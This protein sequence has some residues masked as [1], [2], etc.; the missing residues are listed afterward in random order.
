MFFFVDFWTIIWIF[1]WC[2]FTIFW[3]FFGLEQNFSNMAPPSETTIVQYSSDEDADIDLVA[4]QLSWGHCRWTL[5]WSPSPPELKAEAKS[6]WRISKHWR[7]IVCTFCFCLLAL[8]LIFD[9][10]LK[11]GMF[12]FVTDM[13]AKAKIA[14]LREKLFATMGAV[15]ELEDCA[16][17]N[18]DK[19][20][21]H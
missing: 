10:F 16:F 14:H 4:A 8:A 2:S 20:L 18:V 21:D 7:R 15:P 6:S 12:F 17:L 19:V 13:E 5:L 9:K 1:I 11:S 3:I